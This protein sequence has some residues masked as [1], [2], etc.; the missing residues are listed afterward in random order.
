[1]VKKL[2]ILIIGLASLLGI[3]RWYQYARN[4]FNQ[5]GQ[6]WERDFFLAGDTI[7]FLDS[8]HYYAYHWCDI[9]GDEPGVVGTWRQQGASFVLTSSD[10]KKL[11]KTLTMRVVGN[12]RYLVPFEPRRPSRSGKK[13]ELISG[14][15]PEGQKC[16]DGR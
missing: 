2:L 14:F 16:E 13:H 15:E 10:P 5:P 11:P 8:G 12:C 9:C 4:P 3:W 6:T 7:R 1:M